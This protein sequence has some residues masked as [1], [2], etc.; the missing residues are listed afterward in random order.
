MA[1]QSWVRHQ[2]ERYTAADHLIKTTVCHLSLDFGHMHS[3]SPFASAKWALEHLKH[4]Y[5]IPEACTVSVN[6]SERTS[7]N[8]RNGDNRTAADFLPIIFSQSRTKPTSFGSGPAL[9]H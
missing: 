3:P 1:F 6:T 5:K 8:F 9:Q 2:P 4:C 7:S